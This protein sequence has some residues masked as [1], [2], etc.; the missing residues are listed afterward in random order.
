MKVHFLILSLL[1]S[2]IYTQE[3]TEDP[4]VEED[5]FGQELLEAFVGSAVEIT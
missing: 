3:A 4:V 1:L 5:T 2:S